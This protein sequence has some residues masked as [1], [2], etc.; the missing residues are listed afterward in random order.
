MELYVKYRP[1]VPEDHWGDEFY[2]K[3]ADEVLK[4]CKEEKVIRKDNQAKV[5]AIKE[6]EDVKKGGGDGMK[7]EIK[8]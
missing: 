2:V 7:E 4:K 3:P 5:K 6:G 8:K 1:V